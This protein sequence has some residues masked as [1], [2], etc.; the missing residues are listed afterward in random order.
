[1]IHVSVSLPDKTTTSQETPLDLSNQDSSPTMA[2]SAPADGEPTADPGD[3]VV[4][5]DEA[6]L[7][8]G[9]RSIPVYFCEYV[10]PAS[11]IE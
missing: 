6:A 4:D 2:S 3:A 7:S 9:W 11:Y 5:D 1:M 10:S 8:D